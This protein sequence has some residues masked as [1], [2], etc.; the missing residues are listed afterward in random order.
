MHLGTKSIILL[1]AAA[2]LA[3]GCQ[4]ENSIIPQ[5]LDQQLINAL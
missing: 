2:A 3:A 4:K 5:G 1:L